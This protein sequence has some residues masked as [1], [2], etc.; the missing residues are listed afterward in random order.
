[1]LIRVTEGIDEMEALRI[2]KSE[3][4][5][6]KARRSPYRSGNPDES[7]IRRLPTTDDL[8]DLSDD[9]Q[10]LFDGRRA[11]PP[12]IPA[13][14]TPDDDFYD[15]DHVSLVDFDLLAKSCPPKTAGYGHEMG[16]FPSVPG[17]PVGFRI[18]TAPPLA[19]PFDYELA[20][21]VTVVWMSALVGGLL[22]M[23]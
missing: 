17:I 11:T 5:P 20:F 13:D 22:A 9:V 2:V 19:Q 14:A 8:P 16:P 1:V 21:H 6:E 10:E 12:P 3:S 23:I 15:D 18:S 4:T 7:G